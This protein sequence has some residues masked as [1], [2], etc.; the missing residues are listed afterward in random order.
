MF[1]STLKLID[2]NDNV[3]KEVLG[4]DKT[5]SFL[6]N[7]VQVYRVCQRVK[8]GRQRQN[9]QLIEESWNKIQNK[10]KTTFSFTPLLWDFSNATCSSNNC[11]KICLLELSTTSKETRNDLVESVIT[12]DND[13]SY[14]SICA[15]FWVNIVNQVLPN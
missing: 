12:Q 3:L 10:I 13:C 8:Q 7:L 6:W 11:C 15:N 14:H 9:F 4:N 1:E 2:V 5:K